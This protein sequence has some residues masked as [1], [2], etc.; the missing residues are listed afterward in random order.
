MDQ[1]LERQLDAPVAAGC[2]KVFEDRA[3]GAQAA[4]RTRFTRLP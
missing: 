1:D 4:A 2:D 3:S